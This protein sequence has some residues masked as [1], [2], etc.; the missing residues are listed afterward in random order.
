VDGKKF[1]CSDIW[2]DFD[3]ELYNVTPDGTEKLTIGK[4]TDTSWTDVVTL[5]N[6]SSFSWK[7]FHIHF[8]SANDH[9]FKIGFVASGVNSAGVD[10]WYLDNIHIDYV[11]RPPSG[12]NAVASMTLDTV[13]LSWYPPDCGTSGTLMD[14]IY[15]DGTME[16]GWMM[17]P[18][19]GGWLGN[20]FP[21]STMAGTI[22][23]ISTLWWANTCLPPH[24]T[25][26]LFDENHNYLATTD[27]FYCLSTWTTVPVNHVP[28]NDTFYAMV[29]WTP[30]T[31]CS[32]YLG[33]DEN[34]PFA[35]QD[36][37][38]YTDG[39][40]WQKVSTWPGASPSVFMMRATV[41]VT[42]GMKETEQ[43]PSNRHPDMPEVSDSMIIAGY[44]VYRKPPF[45]DSSFTKINSY[46]VTAAQYMDVP[47]PNYYFDGYYYYV[48]CIYNLASTN[49]F[50]CESPGSDT[51]FEYLVVNIGEKN[52]KPLLKVFPVPANTS[53]NLVSDKI[54][55]YAGIIDHLGITRME[56]R[57]LKQKDCSL[58]VDGLPPGMYV[59]KVLTEKDIITRKILILH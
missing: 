15:D 1:R 41:L 38:W 46:P 5:K 22:E 21:V 32:Y 14:L 51:I 30:T 29:H 8:G 57:N 42:D 56:V 50:L 7:H 54:I 16:N 12:L 20:E 58:M 6:D 4:G 36:L 39:T 59:L 10:S 13:F 33:M 53:V 23:S 35:S 28:F 55:T 40:V 43:Y 47:P 34:G 49:N 45:N 17:S 2:L 48:T 52:E 27:T 25:I 3:L 9:Y 37:A 44:N 19:T 24:M 18:G 26:D 11:C 31:S